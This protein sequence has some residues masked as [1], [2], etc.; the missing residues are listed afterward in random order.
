MLGMAPAAAALAEVEKL[1]NDEA[2]GFIS[3]RFPC[4]TSILMM[5]SSYEPGHEETK[6][7]HTAHS[8]QCQQGCRRIGAVC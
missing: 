1:I 3:C 8:Q 2:Q 6:E 5:S 4:S 7:S